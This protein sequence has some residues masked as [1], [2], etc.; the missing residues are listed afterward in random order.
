[1]SL[2][3]CLLYMGKLIGMLD[4]HGIYMGYFVRVL[5]IDG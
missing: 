4:I 1:M 5:D 3:E 2:L